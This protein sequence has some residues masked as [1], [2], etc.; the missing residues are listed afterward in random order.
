LYFFF[1]TAEARRRRENIFNS[2]WAYAK[3][4][5][6]CGEWRGRQSINLAGWPAMSRLSKIG[7]ANLR[8]SNLA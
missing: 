3:K 1:F 6:E 7:Q 2:N 4:S 5:F 8:G